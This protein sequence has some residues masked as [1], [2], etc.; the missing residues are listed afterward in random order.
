MSRIKS[1]A[2]CEAPRK[3]LIPYIHFEYNIY[4]V[5][6][7]YVDVCSMWHTVRY[8]V[9]EAHALYQPRNTS[10]NSHKNSTHMHIY[11]QRTHIHHSRHI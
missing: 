6:C 1:T 10:T 8:H 9:F 5:F 4:T 3:N 7:I 11:R 2:Q